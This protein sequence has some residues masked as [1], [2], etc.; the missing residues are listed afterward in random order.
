MDGWLLPSSSFRPPP[1]KHEIERGHCL[2]RIERDRH[3]ARDVLGDGAEGG[4]RE[5]AI[6]Q[7]RQEAERERI[8]PGPRRRWMESC[9]AVCMLMEANYGEWE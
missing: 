1:H 5:S 8:R 6:N 9:A 2:R 3:Q 4:E 7:H